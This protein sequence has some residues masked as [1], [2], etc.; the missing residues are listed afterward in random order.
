MIQ[1]YIMTYRLKCKNG[2]FQ[3]LN[4]GE[5][6]DAIEDDRCPD[7]NQSF[8]ECN[9]SISISCPCGF[10]EAVSLDEAK[11]YFATGCPGNGEFEAE[12]NMTYHSLSVKGSGANKYDSYKWGAHG[13]SHTQL[14]LT[15]MPDYWEH[16][17]HFTDE[18]GFL[19]ILKT[20]VIKSSPAGYFLKKYPGKSHAVCL[21]EAPLDY[22]DRFFKRYGS[23]GFVFRKSDLQRIGAQPI[24]TITPR[25]IEAQRKISSDDQL[26]FSDSLLPF[27]QLLRT[28]STDGKG[29][30]YDWLFDREWRSPISIDL[31]TVRPVG[32]TFEYPIVY[33]QMI[34]DL[35]SKKIE[36]AIQYQEIKLRNKP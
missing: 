7:C 23:Y 27:I 3:N 21:T 18:E 9:T 26:S 30:E 2:H 36:A 29:S 35:T 13:P 33:N 4:P 11:G 31:K 24:L 8:I 5:L 10:D 19:N 25:L 28:E 34:D 14:S 1:E 6:N 15:D 17:V 22:A 32:V 20:N 12:A 16:L